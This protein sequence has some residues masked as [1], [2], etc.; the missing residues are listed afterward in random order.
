[1]NPAV[2]ISILCALM[3]AFGFSAGVMFSSRVGFKPP[4][5]HVVNDQS[6]GCSYV[7]SDAG[8]TPRL[9][10]KGS[11]DCEKVLP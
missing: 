4:T 7:L 6:S 1:M 11:P 2:R 10:S 9:D 8:I 5:A 3:W